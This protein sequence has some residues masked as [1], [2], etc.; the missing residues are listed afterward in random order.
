MELREL[1]GVVLRN[2]LKASRVRMSYHNKHKDGSGNF[3]FVIVFEKEGM[4]DV[5]CG[6]QAKNEAWFQISGN[7][8]AEKRLYGLSFGNYSSA[9]ARIPNEWNF[10]E[11]TNYMLKF[12]A[13]SKPQFEPVSIVNDHIK[14]L[15]AQEGKGNF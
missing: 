1:N 15:E 12:I 6:M 11:L 7:Y 10:S 8:T 2:A 9:T 5:G 4:V 13:Q 14:E 3:G